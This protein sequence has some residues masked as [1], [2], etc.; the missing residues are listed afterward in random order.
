MTAK[1]LTT[2]AHRLL[3]KFRRHDFDCLQAFS[4][5]E[6]I[7]WRAREFDDD[8]ALTGV[9]AELRVRFQA[10]CIVDVDEH[11]RRVER[12]ARARFEAS[13]NAPPLPQS[14]QRYRYDQELRFGSRRTR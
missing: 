7:V 5:Y 11:E 6:N 14:D 12:S 3:D 10:H 2:E 1:R 4:V 8:R 13:P 9:I